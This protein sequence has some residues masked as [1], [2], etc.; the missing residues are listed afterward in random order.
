MN[1]RELFL[2]ALEIDSADERRRY[3]VSACGGDSQ[4]QSRV[5][6]LLASH[7]SHS[8]F[9]NKPAMEQIVGDD[10][11]DVAPTVSFVSGANASD[12]DE[13]VSQRD[14]LLDYL[15]PAQAPDSLGRLAHYEILE[16]IGS[17]A[18]GT[19]L[20]GFDEKLQRVVAI[21]VLLP[22]MAVTSP[23][24]K[25]F[26][27]EA[28]SSAQVRHENVVN[29]YAVENDPR[30]Y[31]VM[32]YI[33]GQTLQQRLDDHG[34]LD[35]IEVLRLGKQIAD[36]LA[37]AHAQG[38]I[39]RDVKP[40][41]ILLDTSV[42]NQVKIT[43]F[44]LA[45]TADDASMTQSGMIFGTPLYMAPEQT[46]GQ[47]LDQRADLFS[48]GSVLYQML[49]GR[50]PFRAPNTVA[51]LKRVAEDDPR[52]IQEI[53]PEVPD[54]MCQ[55]V[56]HL[57]EKE[58]DARYGSA[59]EVSDVL[60]KCLADVQASRQ[61]TSITPTHA[62]GKDAPQSPKVGLKRTQRLVGIPLLRIAAVF[63]VLVFG[64]GLTEATG[65]TDL[66]STVIRLATG[67]GTL[68]IETD[69]PT[70]KISIDGEAITIRGSGIEELTLKPGSYDFA[71]TKDG[72]Q[73]K[74][75]LVTINRNDRTIVK[76]SLEADDRQVPPAGSAST[77]EEP[78]KLSPF[79]DIRFED[80]DIYV[81]FNGQERKLLELDGIK[82][83][84]IVRS[85]Q[86]QFGV[87]WQ[88]RISEDLVEVLW[89]MNHKPEDTVQLR[90]LDPETDEELLVEKAPLT[91]RNRS[92][93]YLRRMNDELKTQGDPAQGDPTQ[94]GAKY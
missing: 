29:I 72:E 54:W 82:V 94:A 22:E 36:G 42:D 75:E 4:L 30:P 89:G 62:E 44:G 91:K 1:E 87:K 17:G 58:P 24:R 40:G 69:D 76:M 67:S 53:I 49:S 41:N 55:I 61:P 86:R 93:I 57:H 3:L 26:L 45:R 2:A 74:R 66:T 50:P 68:V 88:K 92:E 14:V 52:P 10:L 20:K 71:A 11:E 64:L 15:E 12:D 81:T 43:D 90:L 70:V 38:L 56:G 84:D 80:E 27:R 33:P 6:T 77:L 28:R 51:V 46:L 31:L 79:T 65:V 59:K 18:F 48:L 8:V 47:K 37:A 73:V 83:E 13:G 23:A 9:L 34:P 16:V 25:R 35:L 7:E 63:L 19:V 60:G 32:E 21:K 78:P 5:E 85:A 39:H